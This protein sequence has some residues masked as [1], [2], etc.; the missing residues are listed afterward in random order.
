MATDACNAVRLHGKKGFKIFGVFG[1]PYH[2]ASSDGDDWDSVLAKQAGFESIGSHDFV[3]VN[4][5]VFDLKH[6]CGSS[7][8]PHGRHTAVAKERLWNQLWGDGQPQA[9]VI[10]RGHVHFHNFC[11]G[12]GWIAMTL[13]ALQGAG[14]KFGARQ[15]S[16]TV[17]YGITV[18]DVDSKG[19][20]DWTCD[21]V[22]FEAQQA[23]AVKA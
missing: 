3:D 6:K 20:F 4:S 17:D 22:Q 2:C 16:G 9:N 19:Q 1:T 14:S 18:F 8:I 21:T 7:A 23:T 11:G 15:C 13:P 5:C 10:L 12:P